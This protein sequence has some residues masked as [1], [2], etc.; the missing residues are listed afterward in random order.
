MEAFDFH[1]TKY[2]KLHWIILRPLAIQCTIVMIHM[3][4][5]MCSANDSDC[6]CME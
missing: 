5:T 2:N 3:S 1:L 6:E 4:G